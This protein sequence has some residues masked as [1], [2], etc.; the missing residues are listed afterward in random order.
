M[1]LADTVIEF[2]IRPDGWFHSIQGGFD[3]PRGP[4]G[5]LFYLAFVPPFW[6]M[7][8]RWRAH[9]LAAT[10]LLLTVVTVGPAFA[11]MLAVLALAG[12]ALIRALGNDRGYALGATLL[13]GSYAAIILHPQPGWLPPVSEPLFF[14]VHWAG[15]AYMFLKTLHV[16][17]D[18]SR[19]KLA[20]PY[21]SEWLAYILFAPSLRMGPMYRYDEFSEQLRGDLAAHRQLGRAVGRIV[22]GLVRLGVLGALL[23]KPNFPLDVLFGDPGQWSPTRFI[24][25][26]Y[27]APMC[28]FLW[29]SGY[30]ELGVGIGRAMGFVVPE[31]FNYPWIAVNIGEFWQRW[32]MTLGSWLRDYIFTPLVRRRWHFFWAFTLTFFLCGLWHS[33]R[34][35]Y[36]IWGTA[37]GVGLAVLRIWTH[38]WKRQRTAGTPLYRRLAAVRLVNSPITVALAWLLTF[39]YEV[40]TIL[41]GM[42][43]QHAGKLVAFHA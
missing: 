37:Q 39:H 2:A 41:I 36:V 5:V 1:I 3:V 26:V 23:D 27:L 14:Y 16:L 11:V 40:V 24:L 15:I 31:N 17:N 28:A 10:S 29:F 33:N 43:I 38:Y 7:P 4:V 12:F 32:H 9:Y 13:V 21:L 20:P 34:W 19:R 18:L 42:D 22:S 30:V 35:C 8:T 6:L 25:G